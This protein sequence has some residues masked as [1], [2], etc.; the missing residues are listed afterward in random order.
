[1]DDDRGHVLRGRRMGDMRDEMRMPVFGGW[2][3]RMGV[4]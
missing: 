4:H 3:G 1:M 2:V